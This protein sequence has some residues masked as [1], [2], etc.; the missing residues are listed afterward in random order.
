MKK[1]S[2]FIAV[3]AMVSFNACEETK[4]SAD[5]L[6]GNL[7]LKTI[8]ETGEN[9]LKSQINRGQVPVYI[10]GLDID[11]KD[12]SGGVLNHED[13]QYV[14]NG[15]GNE[16][17]IEGVNIVNA[18]KIEATSLPVNDCNLP[19]KFFTLPD[20]NL[21]DITG[22]ETG[23]LALLDHI[24]GL[25]DG[26][27]TNA[28]LVPYAEYYGEQTF[29]MIAGANN[30]TTVTLDTNNG[31]D[32]G[33]IVNNSV[34][35]VIVKM[36]VVNQSGMGIVN[37]LEYTFAPNSTEAIGYYWGNQYATALTTGIRFDFT[38]KDAYGVV[39]KTDYSWGI[40]DMAKESYWS[41]ISVTNSGIED[42]TLSTIFKFE[43]IEEKG[44]NQ[45]I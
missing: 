28:D 3:L 7:K 37:D 4:I 31:R 6:E 42:E 17:L 16:I 45:D 39:V 1:L 44:G 5:T 40:I 2:L 36:H 11:V 30:E 38:W 25:Y 10:S 34:Y 27:W 19:V 35:T 20:Q 14:D 13:V 43:E 41:R 26:N 23:R 29:S 12:V 15:G 33:T 9:N 32:F 21:V 24:A 8:V 22:S 18:A